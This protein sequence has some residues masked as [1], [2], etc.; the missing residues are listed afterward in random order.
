MIMIPGAI[1]TARIWRM[2]PG[3]DDSVGGAMITG[4]PVYTVPFAIAARRPSQES[5]EQGLEVRKIF[6]GTTRLC[7]VT[8][9]ER[10]EVEVTC[11]PNHPYYGLRFR[12][13]GVQPSKRRNGAEQHCTLERIERSRRQQ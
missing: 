1:L 3:T 13:T 4:T 5:L 8:L 9:Y 11:P 10:D 12:I 7:G 6:D 2:L